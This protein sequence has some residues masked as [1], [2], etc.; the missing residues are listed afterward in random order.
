[1]KK[2]K[3]VKIVCDRCGNHDHIRCS[4]WFAYI[5]VR[6]TLCDICFYGLSMGLKFD[7]EKEI[8]D[9]QKNNL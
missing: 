5:K 7:I 3:E 4:L 2:E 8:A 1:M 9:R 6:I